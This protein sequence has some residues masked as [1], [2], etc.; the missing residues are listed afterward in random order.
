ELKL[1][2]NKIDG[3]SC[4]VVLPEGRSAIAAF[5]EKRNASILVN[6]VGT[7]IR[8]PLS[9][10][11]D[12]ELNTLFQTNLMSAIKLTRDLYPVLKSANGASVVNIGSV[13]GHIHI[14]TGAPYGMTKA[15]LEQLTRNLAVEWASDGIRVNLVAPWYIRT[16]LVEPVLSKPDYYEEVVNRTPLKRIGL[17][18]EVGGIAA[19][20]C[21]PIAGYIT[22][23]IISVDGG[24]GVNGF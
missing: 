21:L 4:D 19:F 5:A 7:N 22:G 18:K 15:A 12:E 14:R 13:A 20:L 1:I 6:N 3:F 2:S 8:K 16:P 11:T 9:E 10:Y 24:F 23:Q 17:P